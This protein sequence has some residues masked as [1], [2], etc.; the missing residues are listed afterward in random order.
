MYD[1]VGWGVPY[2]GSLV[3][4]ERETLVDISLQ[5]NTIIF[6]IYYSTDERCKDR[7]LGSSCA[8]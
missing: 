3:A 5:V 1:P 4:D 2:A 6:I 7:S 8:S